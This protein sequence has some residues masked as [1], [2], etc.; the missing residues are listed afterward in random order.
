MG[1]KKIVKV[2][3]IDGGGIRGVIPATFC[4]HLETIT[5]CTVPMWKL[6]D[7]IVGTS[8]GGAITM[9]LTR[10]DPV[11]PGRARFTAQD[12]VNLYLQHGKDLFYAPPEYMANNAYHLAPEIPESSIVDTLQKFLPKP[13]CELKDALTDVAVTAYDL[14]T[15]KP[16]MFSSLLA[17][18]NPDGNFYMRDVVQAS[19]AFPGL[20]AA[21]EITS[22]GGNRSLLCIDGGMSGNSPIVQS[23]AYAFMATKHPELLFAPAE[24]AAG[25]VPDFAWEGFKGPMPMI[26]A[27][28]DPD[29]QV[30]VVSLG[31]GH[32]LS[33]IPYDTARPWGFLQWGAIVTDVMF[34]ATTYTAEYEARKLLDKKNYFRFQVNLPATLSGMADPSHVETLHK[35][36]DKAISPG[37][38][39][40]RE[41]QRLQKALAG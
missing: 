2:L 7:F 15:R 39:L 37:G 14:I 11:R 12:C 1:R 29:I 28:P 22:V 25:A 16:L 26:F 35:L 27:Q 6:F 5:G 19:A 34:D 10:P 17:K 41:F 20:F 38:R 9:L 4:A 3:A 18:K 13:D 36:A 21:A 24:Q 23:Y 30:I 40:Y 8:T 33:R 31:T 32:Y